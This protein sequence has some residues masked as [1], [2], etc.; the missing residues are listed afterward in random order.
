M[1]QREALQIAFRELSANPRDTIRLY[2]FE[3]YSFEEIATKLGQTRGN[4]KHHYFR[5]LEK[6]RR[7]VFFSPTQNQVAPVR[8]LE[9]IGAA[10]ST[11]KVP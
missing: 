6:L 7:Q 9:I 3:G 8:V 4:V 2:F 1:E 5:G 11:R 10:R